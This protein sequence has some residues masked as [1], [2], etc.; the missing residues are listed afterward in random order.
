[1]PTSLTI[2]CLDTEVV[3]ALC[4]AHTGVPATSVR[5]P[6]DG[7]AGAH[8][9][10]PVSWLRA[11][12]SAVG[13]LVGGGDLSAAGIDH[14]V[15]CVCPKGAVVLDADGGL[16]AP[17]LV[18]DDPDTAPDAKWLTKQLPGGAD[19]WVAAVGSAPSAAWTAS[20]LSWLHRSEPSAWD[21]LAVVL[22]PQDWVALQL[23]GNVFTDERSARATGYWS[24]TDFY[25]LDLLAI[26]DGDRDWT[27]ALPPVVADHAA[28]GLWRGVP[29]HLHVA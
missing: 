5:V 24:S 26:V 1:M 3:A 18:G 19:D 28:V 11:L 12:E 23:T 2:D 8:R 6:Y 25:R 22:Q 17:A 29:V 21:Q 10:D 13:Q 9:V 14:V 27:G 7:I 15:L 4:D 16:L 20:K